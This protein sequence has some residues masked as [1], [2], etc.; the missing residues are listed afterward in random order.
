MP[1]L[2]LYR[3]G[4][5]Q[6]KPASAKACACALMVS[7]TPHHSCAGGEWMGRGLEEVRRAC[8]RWLAAGRAGRRARQ[9]RP[10]AA[11]RGSNDGA[12]CFWQH[13]RLGCGG[14]LC[15]AASQGAGALKHLQH[16]QRRRVGGAGDVA[17]QAVAKGDLLHGC[18][19]RSV[20]A[21]IFRRWMVRIRVRIRG[22]QDQ[23]AAGSGADQGQDQ[24]PAA[25]PIEPRRP[26]GGLEHHSSVLR[27]TEYPRASG[28][29]GGRERGARHG[30]T[31]ASW[32]LRCS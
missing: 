7:L 10:Q 28:S 21:L 14:L 5:R 30:T 25:R 16:D 4:T 1:S 9:G 17:G 24:G 11:S 27:A 12:G 15:E 31:G 32:P 29:R 22:R 13:A 26:S 18:C 6:R 19:A 20:V 8:Q 3:S 23:G 2:P